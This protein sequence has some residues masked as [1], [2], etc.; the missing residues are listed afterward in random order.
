MTDLTSGGYLY[1]KEM[2]RWNRPYTFK[3]FPKMLYKAHQLPSGKWATSATF[4]S[5]TGG[6]VG[7]AEKFSTRCTLVV[8]DQAE[9][10]RAMEN[11]WR[12]TPG[13]AMEYCRKHQDAI[14]DATA[15]RHYADSK[16]SEKAQAEAKAAD[17]EVFEHLPEIPE[18]RRVGRPRKEA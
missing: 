16:M 15:E 14:G 10:Q 18:K 2:E 17:A 3:P 1:Q 4:D 9:Y 13:D 12:E 6:V 8:N 5:Q 7:S 11:G